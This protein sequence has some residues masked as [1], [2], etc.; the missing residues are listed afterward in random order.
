MAGLW[1]ND[2]ALAGG[3]GTRGGKYPV[4]L[5]RDGTVP[6][7]EW[8][9]F[10]DGDAAAVAALRSYADEAEKLGYEPTYVAD[11]RSMAVEWE[12]RQIEERASRADLP[13][14]PASDPC[15]PRHRRDDPEVLSFPSS[16][17][18]YRRGIRGAGPGRSA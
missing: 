12:L 13:S 18:E 9:V 11:V 3:G 1:R 4:I 6:D 10:L 15:A 5:R 17:D 7:R 2:P 16:L 14:P 8:F